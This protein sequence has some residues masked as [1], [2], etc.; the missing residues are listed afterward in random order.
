MT[1]HITLFLAFICCSALL[2]ARTI[3]GI[4]LSSKDS[5]AVAGA[6]CRL[7]S[8]SDFITGTAADSTGAFGLETELKTDLN[9]EITMA[10]YSPTEIFIES[11]TKTSVSAPSTSTRP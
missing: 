6:N 1:R 10:G 9:L 11:G 8:G 3:S 2:N 5:T 7:I 4:V